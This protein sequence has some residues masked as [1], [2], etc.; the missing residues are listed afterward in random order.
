M[1]DITEFLVEA[2]RRGRGSPA[3]KY[4]IVAA[5]RS[6]W[7]SYQQWNQLTVPEKFFPSLH[8]PLNAANPRVEVTQPVDDVGTAERDTEALEQK[9]RTQYGEMT[10]ISGIVQWPDGKFSGLVNAYYSRS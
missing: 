5:S 2:V 3:S 9:R 4:P 8:F 7:Y 1:A 10:H 6:C